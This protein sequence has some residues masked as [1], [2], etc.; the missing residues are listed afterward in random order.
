[1]ILVKSTDYGKRQLVAGQ[2]LWVTF[3]IGDFPGKQA[4]LDWCAGHFGHLPAD[5]F[6]NQCQPRNLRPPA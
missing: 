1:M 2:P 6:T 5:E 3:V 4:V